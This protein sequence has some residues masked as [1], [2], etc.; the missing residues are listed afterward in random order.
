MRLELKCLVKQTTIAPCLEAQLHP[1]PPLEHIAI[2]SPC[3]F[4]TIGRS[5]WLVEVMQLNPNLF[6]RLVEGGDPW[7]FEGYFNEIPPLSR[8]TYTTMRSNCLHT[9]VA[10]RHP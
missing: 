9:R 5:D 3:Y 4:L 7:N 8:W 1:F 10:A 2:N 6:F